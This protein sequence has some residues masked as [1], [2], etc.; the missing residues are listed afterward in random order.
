MLN[1]TNDAAHH[2]LIKFPQH[3]PNLPST[4]TEQKPGHANHTS[5]VQHH[6]QH[7]EP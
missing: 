2:I 4:Q 5:T 7:L 1:S 3:V 6:H